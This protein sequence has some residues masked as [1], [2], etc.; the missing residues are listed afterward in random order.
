MPH[1]LDKTLH[2]MQ[3]LFPHSGVGQVT[4]GIE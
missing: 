4:R 1:E 3:Q 2:K